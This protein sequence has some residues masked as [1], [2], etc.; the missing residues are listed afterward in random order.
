[1]PFTNSASLAEQIGVACQASRKAI[2][3]FAANNAIGLTATFNATFFP[4]GGTEIT[5]ASLPIIQGVVQSW[6]DQF[7]S[8]ME[9][10]FTYGSLLIGYWL[11]NGVIPNQSW[12][13]LVNGNW[14][15]CMPDGIAY[16]LA[17]DGKS[18]QS[19]TYTQPPVA[20]TVAFT[21]ASYSIASQGSAV[22]IAITGVV[23]LTYQWALQPANGD[24]I[25]GSGTLTASLETIALNAPAL[26]VGTVT[27]TVTLMDAW[28][29]V[30][31]AATATTE[32]TA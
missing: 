14:S 31:P 26:A 21:A 16:A 12:C 3:T 20:P 30:S 25:T 15:P 22:T 1:M 9:D 28:E 17:P 10:H 11:E 8:H 19:I 18:C 2:D 13:K 29:R 5:D 23:G 6:G 7:L 24:A 27:L 32:L 4:L